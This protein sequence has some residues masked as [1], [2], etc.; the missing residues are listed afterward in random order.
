LNSE[1]PSEW[2]YFTSADARQFLSEDALEA[3]L[4]RQAIFGLGP[5]VLTDGF[6]FGPPVTDHVLEAGDEKSLFEQA[7]EDGMVVPITRAFDRRFISNAEHLIH[8]GIVP[9]KRADVARHVAS[10]FQDLT[11]K[12]MRRMSWPN[13]KD[14]LVGGTLHDKLSVL[15]TEY[16]PEFTKEIFPEF[17]F[18]NLEEI[19]HGTRELREAFISQATD[20]S[21]PNSEP[22]FK[23]SRFFTLLEQHYG[24]QPGDALVD[25]QGFVQSVIER[26]ATEG[27][28]LFALIQW[29][30][31]L[32]I[33]NLAS[34]FGVSVNIAL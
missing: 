4:I 30:N 28:A 5:H 33:E 20:Y 13:K 29:V 9:A 15:R 3:A 32:Y 8:E 25:I 11:R 19:W 18:C 2:T 7:M 17:E 23:R 21:N 1:N 26:D 16:L 27:T 14:L 6:C 31:F 22:D 12:R 10:R 34:P 24:A